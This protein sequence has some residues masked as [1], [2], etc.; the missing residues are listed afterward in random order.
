VSVRLIAEIVGV[1]TV[2][3]VGWLCRQKLIKHA[4]WLLKGGAVNTLLETFFN[5][6]A[7]LW[8]VFPLVDALY[9]VKKPGEVGINIVLIVITSWLA[10]GVFFY[11]AVLSK[12]FA[13]NEKSGKPEEKG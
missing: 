9:R 3:G 13:G 11:F 1:A 7:V 5:E 6:A 10:A 2:G 8:F 12:K 4:E